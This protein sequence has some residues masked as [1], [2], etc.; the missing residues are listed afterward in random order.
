MIRK[1]GELL[2]L[3]LTQTK[4]PVR[5]IILNSEGQEYNLYY[6]YDQEVYA[7]RWLG[8]QI[9]PGGKVY[10]DFSGHDR[11]VSQGGIPITSTSNVVAFFER[12]KDLDGYIYLRHYNIVDGKLIGPSSTEERELADYWSQL[13]KENK[14]YTNGGSEIWR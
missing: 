8:E 9:E 12:N 10:A 14:I 4:P 2:T 11:V 6:V 7:C 3:T 13:S 1:T 5:T